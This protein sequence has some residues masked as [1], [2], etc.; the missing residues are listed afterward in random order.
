MMNTEIKTRCSF[1]R[2]SLKR[3]FATLAVVVFSVALVVI[4]ASGRYLV[5]TAAGKPT[6]GNLES[7]L[8]EPKLDIQQVHKGGRFPNALVAVEGT[9]LALWGGVKVRRS[10]D[11]GQTWGPEIM[12]GKGFMSG[13]AIVN[14][15]NGDIL[16]FVEKNHPPAPLTVYRS[17][18][19][20]KTWS[21]MEVVIKPD[22]NGNVPSMHMNESGITLRHGRHV[23]RIIR[24]ARHYAG[25]NDRSKWPQHYTTAI[26]SDDGGKTWNTSKPFAEMGTGEAAIAELSDGRLYYN[27]RS[28]WNK[29]KPP[30]RRRCAFSADGGE[31][32]R[33]WQIVEILPDGPQDTTYGCMGGLVRL[34]IQGK[35]IL[36]FSNCD[37]PSG[38]RLGTVWASFDGGKTW[39]L[40]RRVHEGSFAYSSLTAGRP[41][42]KSEG[43]IYLH[44]ESSGSKVA[45]FNLSWLLKGEKT[46]DGELPNWLPHQQSDSEAIPFELFASFKRIEKGNPVFE[47][48]LPEWAAAAHAIVVDEKIHYLWALREKK[49]RRWRMMHSWAPV[50]DPSA[51]THDSRNPILSPSVDGFDNAATEYPFP[52]WNPVDRTYYA[53]YLG[54]KRTVPKQTGLLVREEDFGKWKRLRSEPVIAAEAEY[55]KDGSSHPSVAVVGKTI[56]IIYTGESK[57]PPV[58]CHATAPV[59]DPANVTK[60]PAN[61]IFKGTGKTWDSRGVREAEIF[62]GPR[63]FHILYGGHDGKTWR[64]GH[65][66]TLDFRRFEANPHNPVFVPS[67]EAGAWDYDGILTPQVFVAG[68]FYYL[69]YAGKKGNEWQTGLA[70]TK[71]P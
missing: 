62:K 31:T 32:W 11:G 24:A 10:E 7:F 18:D 52:F 36:I 6:E 3:G 1:F 40:K 57:Q 29:N 4:E 14:E 69:L 13:G 56:H 68:D 51:V 16:T 59:S 44:F 50:S 58:I 67:T 2:T 41:G 61:P 53:Y 39:P 20:G 17:K 43:W 15:T 23:G 30:K 21:P 49:G 5:R 34:P 66:R 48:E 25:R 37:S 19:H 71:K 35:D 45:R 27:S 22:T 65:V 70:K 63:Y 54:R 64:I 47:G 42:T 38:R 33:G 8:G 26:Y 9:V 12:V 55:E 60:D 46:G 28:H